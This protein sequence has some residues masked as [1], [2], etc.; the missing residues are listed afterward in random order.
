MAT[1]LYAGK[2]RLDL[3]DLG[4]ELFWT[5]NWKL[6]IGTEDGLIRRITTHDVLLSPATATQKEQKV[7]LSSDTYLTAWGKKVW[8]DAPAEKFVQDLDDEYPGGKPNVVGII[9]LG[10]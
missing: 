4:I 9:N 3:S 10:D 6:W 1:T 2:Q 5:T 7:V 8:I